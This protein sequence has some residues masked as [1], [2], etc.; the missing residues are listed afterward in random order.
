VDLHGFSPEWA[1]CGD[2]AIALQTLPQAP[3]RQRF[4][5]RFLRLHMA[6]KAVENVN[7]PGAQGKCPTTFQRPRSIASIE[8][9]ASSSSR[10]C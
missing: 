1:F 6:V 10:C 8:T 2:P 9:N 3:Q 4:G 7:S 5:E